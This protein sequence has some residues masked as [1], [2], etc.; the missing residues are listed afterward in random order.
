MLLKLFLLKD[1]RSGK[2]E[3]VFEYPE[4][5]AS[6]TLR[7]RDCRL[8]SREPF[9]IPILVVPND[10]LTEMDGQGLGDD[11]LY[12][13]MEYV[14]YYLGNIKAEKKQQEYDSKIEK[15]KELFSPG[16]NHRHHTKTM[17][18]TGPKAV[19]KKTFEN[20]W[21]FSQ[22]TGNLSLTNV[23]YFRS[24]DS[25]SL[26][27]INDVFITGTFECGG[28]VLENTQC[29]ISMLNGAAPRSSNG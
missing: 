8:V 5:L 7:T 6:P 18:F 20:E 3:Q 17:F 26:K 14:D 23:G 22:M 27:G 10:Y 21:V 13:S 16:V 19:Y 25:L 28:E 1:P 11:V 15:V 12:A 29:K 4:C 24:I 9:R 2:I